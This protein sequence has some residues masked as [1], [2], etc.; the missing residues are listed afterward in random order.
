MTLVSTSVEV[1]AAGF[2]ETTLYVLLHTEGFLNILLWFPV[3]CNWSRALQLM[4]S[5]VWVRA[6]CS[7]SQAEKSQI[8]IL[9]GPLCLYKMNIF[10]ALLCLGTTS[11]GFYLNLTD[12]MRGL[13]RRG[14]SLLFSV[15]FKKKIIYFQL[16]VALVFFL[17]SFLCQRH[18]L[19]V[20]T[21][22]FFPIFTHMLKIHCQCTVWSRLFF[23]VC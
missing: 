11:P 19:D 4:C 14:T 18:F 6:A 23:H 1:T 5:L 13:V 22:C 20:I 8:Q 3:H 21:L 12:F 7:R 2:A 15:V 9:K 17:L 10:Y 16:I